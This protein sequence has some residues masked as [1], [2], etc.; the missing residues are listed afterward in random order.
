MNYQEIFEN[1]EF[2]ERFKEVA[3]KDELQSLF[4]EYGLDLSRAEI[5]EVVAGVTANNTIDEVDPVSLENVTGGKG[6]AYNLDL[7]SVISWCCYAFKKGWEWGSKF[8]DW[9]HRQ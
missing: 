2:L 6:K 7:K 4:S 1:Q 3:G 9:E 8:Y 5:D